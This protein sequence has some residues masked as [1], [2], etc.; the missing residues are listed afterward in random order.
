MNRKQLIIMWVGLLLAIGVWLEGN[1]DEQ[2]EYIPIIVVVTVGLLISFSNKSHK[3]QIIEE[4][5]KDTKDKKG[6]S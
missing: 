4:L 1:R 2:R 5:R 3:A 6:Y